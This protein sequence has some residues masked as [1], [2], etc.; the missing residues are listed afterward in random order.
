MIWN[1]PRVQRVPIVVMLRPPFAKLHAGDERRTWNEKPFLLNSDSVL[2]IKDIKLQDIKSKAYSCRC[3]KNQACSCVCR[4]WLLS[5]VFALVVSVLPAA[6]ALLQPGTG[7]STAT[8]LLLY[9]ANT[10]SRWGLAGFGTAAP[11]APGAHCAVLSWMSAPTLCERDYYRISSVVANN[12]NSRDVKLN[13]L[14]VCAEV[15]LLEPDCVCTV[16][17]WNSAME[18]NIQEIT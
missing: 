10:H 13:S 7:L 17:L 18:L 9:V 4:T 14:I 1:L 15:T 3:S 12:Q 11:K 2:D 5:T 16:C 6:T 8:G